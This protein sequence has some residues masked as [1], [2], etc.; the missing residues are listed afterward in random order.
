MSTKA[1]PTARRPLSH[2]QLEQLQASLQESLAQ[3]LSRTKAILDGARWA[4]RLTTAMVVH[5][6]HFTVACEV[7]DKQGPRGPLAEHRLSQPGAPLVSPR[8]LA[9][10][11]LRARSQTPSLAFA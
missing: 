9:S 4:H 8:S 2:H 3:R 1:T 6:Q 11:A 7:A 10:Q 5:R